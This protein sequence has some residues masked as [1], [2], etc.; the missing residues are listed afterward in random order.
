METPEISIASPDRQVRRVLLVEDD[1]ITSTLVRHR[2]ERE[3]MKVSHLTHGTDALERVQG[4]EAPEFDLI[5]LDVKLPG[6]SGFDV[7]REIRS[8]ALWANV[9]IVMLTGMGRD[10]DV[11]RAFELGAD[12]Y[13]HKPFSP[14]ELMARVQ[15]FFRVRRG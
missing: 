2:L 3:G 5:L 8:K 10:A 13:I 14:V 4:M 6:A 7:L 11:V 12:E 1:E 15:R 9:P